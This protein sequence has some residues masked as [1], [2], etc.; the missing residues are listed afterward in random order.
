MGSLRMGSKEPHKA[1]Y[2]FKRKVWKYRARNVHRDFD[3]VEVFSD[4]LEGIGK[5]FGNMKMHTLRLQL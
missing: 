4:T 2:E 3:A 1:R 5:R